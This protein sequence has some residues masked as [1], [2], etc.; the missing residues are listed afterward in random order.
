M[1]AKC[2]GKSCEENPLEIIVCGDKEYAFCDLHRSKH[3]KKCSSSHSIS[4]LYLKLSKD[5]RNQFIVFLNENLRV[6]S[7]Q[8]EAL[9]GKVSHIIIRLNEITSNILSTFKIQKKMYSDLLKCIKENKSLPV[10]LFE[11]Q[12]NTPIEVYNLE[13]LIKNNFK[14]FYEQ[15]DC[16]YQEFVNKLKDQSIFSDIIQY[17][18]EKYNTDAVYD[19]LKEVNQKN[20]EISEIDEKPLIKMSKM[21]EYRENPEIYDYIYKL[22]LIGNTMTGKTELFNLFKQDHEKLSDSFKTIMISLDSGL[23]VKLQIWD[24][25]GI[26]KY[27]PLN[28]IYVKGAK[29]IA[30]I[31]SVTD[32]QTFNSIPTLLSDTIKFCDNDCKFILLG[33]NFG[34]FSNDPEIKKVPTS[35]GEEYAK[36]KN[37]LFA[38]VS[39]KDKESCYAAFKKL[40]E[41]IVKNIETEKKKPK[42]KRK[43]FK[44]FK[45]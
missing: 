12:K 7:T 14:G 39:S 34:N 43:W 28:S 33:N 5:K 18:E 24:T 19:S 37:L 31:Y 26:E 6:L 36:M 10:N 11:D 3:L 41:E 29:G 2:D 8:S 21:Q 30:L 38:E 45:S 23:I 25:S 44:F 42:K 27:K 20:N 17:H 4:S 16:K 9:I 40:S 13:I 35:K 15:A 22:V 32:E 1:E